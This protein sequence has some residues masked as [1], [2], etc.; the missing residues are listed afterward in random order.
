VFAVGAGPGGLPMIGVYNAQTGAFLRQIDAFESFGGGVRVAV[1]RLNGQDV[2]V[3]AAGP[4]GSPLIS[5]HDA[6]GNPLL[7]NRPVF[8]DSFRGGVRVAVVDVNG[9]GKAQIVA[10]KG[11]GSTPQVQIV[12]GRTFAKVGV[13]FEVFDHG[14]A[15]GVFV[16]GAVLDSSGLGRIVVGADSAN[17][18]PND[19]PVLRAFDGVGNLVR[20]YAP[21]LESNYHGGITVAGTRAFGRT[22]DTV[23][24]GPARTH[25]PTVTALDENFKALPNSFAVLNPKTGAADTANFGNGLDVG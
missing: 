7:S 22:F 10:A 4:G 5:V 16:T 23:L 24:A 18:D 6:S 1:G 9:T 17:G 3:A 14:F 2:I 12:D 19:A 20:N 8:E 15:G 25:S 11:G 21:A 13:P